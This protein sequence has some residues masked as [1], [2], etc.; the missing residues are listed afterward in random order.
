MTSSEP[1]DPLA[2]SRLDARARARQMRRLLSDPGALLR[3]MQ[4][5][6]RVGAAALDFAVL[7]GPSARLHRHDTS[8][9]E[10]GGH[11]FLG[12]WPEKARHRR[13]SVTLGSRPTYLS[14][15]REGR[16]VTTGWVILGEGTQAS[17]RGDLRI[18]EGTY[19][20]ADARFIVRE[21]VAV[22]RECAIAWD[23]LV[24]DTDE[25]PLLID[26]AIREP[27]APVTIGDHVWIGARSAV[28]KGVTV[29]DGAV[30]AAQSVVTADVPARAVVAGSPARVVRTDVEW[31]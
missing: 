30:V 2:W 28:L 1:A 9:I 14:V 20:N 3:S 16:F 18:G 4:L 13:A 23:V 31:W 17:V 5:S 8:H 15:E 11:L 6:R 21:S 25:H 24:M 12:F 26:G 19:V 29:G 22:G 10:L 27:T 7:A